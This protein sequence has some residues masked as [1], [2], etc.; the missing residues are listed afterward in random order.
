M[1]GANDDNLDYL[2]GCSSCLHFL[3]ENGYGYCRH[4]HLGGKA[5]VACHNSHTKEWRFVR[6]CEWAANC[7]FKTPNT[8]SRINED[9]Q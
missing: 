9:K 1:S 4:W 2:V 8:A 3:L 7:N 6:G 5:L